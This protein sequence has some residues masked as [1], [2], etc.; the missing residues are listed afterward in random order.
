[1]I[2]PKELQ[3]QDLE[4]QHSNHVDTVKK[5]RLLTCKFIYEINRNTDIENVIKQWYICLDFVETWSKVY[6]IHHEIPGRPWEV[7]G[8]DMFSVQ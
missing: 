2:I 8:I 1:M 7:I 6:I 4:Q 5:M 3:K